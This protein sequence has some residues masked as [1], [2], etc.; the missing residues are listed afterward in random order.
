M[1]AMPVH[2][3]TYGFNGQHR[4]EDHATAVTILP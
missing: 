4:L 3:W 2:E 1:R